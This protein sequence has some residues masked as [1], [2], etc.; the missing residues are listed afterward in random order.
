[1]GTSQAANM[2]RRTTCQSIVALIAAYAIAIQTFLSGGIMVAH[3]AAA[4]DICAI[5][6][7]VGGPA[8]QPIGHEND[9]P[10]GPACTMAACD[11]PVGLVDSAGVA[12][13][14]SAV[15]GIK[16]DL[17]ARPQLVP[18]KAASGSNRQRAPPIS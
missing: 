8:E 15:S 6:N 5:H 3:A 11:G 14:W 1:M 7:E 10:C 13:I 16:L 17:N 18:T 4:S 2:R 12:I 9:C